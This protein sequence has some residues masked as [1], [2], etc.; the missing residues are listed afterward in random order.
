MFVITSSSDLTI[1]ERMPI[2]NINLNYTKTSPFCSFDRR[3]AIKEE[4]W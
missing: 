1:V 3:D 4:I 2:I